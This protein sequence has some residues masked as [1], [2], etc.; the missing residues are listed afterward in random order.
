MA[1]LEGLHP[2]GVGFGHVTGRLDLVVEHH[3]RAPAGGLLCRRY[4]HGV[5]QVVIGVGSHGRRRTHGSR[6]HDGP[7]V[8]HRQ[9]QEI[10]RFLQRG[11]AVGHRRAGGFRVGGEALVDTVRQHQPVVGID[12][13]TA[14]VDDL[15]GDHIGQLVGFRHA[16]QHL[17]NSQ[18]TALIAVVGEIGAILTH[19]GYGAPGS[20]QIHPAPGFLCHVNPPCQPARQG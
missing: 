7:A 3:Q 1:G 15:L 20:E 14:Y 8:P 5:Q 6:Y 12:L 19:E 16:G 10:G 9:V 13:R 2:I 11:G 4:P 17:I 18:L